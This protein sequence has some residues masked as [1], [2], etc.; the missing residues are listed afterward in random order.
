[1]R[2]DYELVRR[3]LTVAADA[4]EPFEIECVVDSAHSRR[5]V[6]RHVALL[7]DA[8]LVRATIVAA[9]DD[10]YYSV[11]V[12]GTTFEGQQLA[13][14]VRSDSVWDGCK[15]SLARVG[16]TVAISVFSELVKSAAMRALG[17]S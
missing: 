11:V 16:G 2:T 12:S 7:V 13:D 5:K 17:L 1:M 8:G 4:V 10:P 3:I 6:G 9:E 15:S 14:C